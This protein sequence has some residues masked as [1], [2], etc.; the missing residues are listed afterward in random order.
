MIVARVKEVVGPTQQSP[1]FFGYQSMHRFVD[2]KPPHVASVT[3]SSKAVAPPEGAAKN[4]LISVLR[5]SVRDRTSGVRLIHWAGSHFRRRRIP[6][7][8]EG[9]WPASIRSTG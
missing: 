9:R 1:P 2:I 7:T 8:R 5:D 6:M 3:A 4:P